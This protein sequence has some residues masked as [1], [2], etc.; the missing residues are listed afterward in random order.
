[1]RMRNA[2]DSE[3]SNLVIYS[4]AINILT[5]R[6]IVARVP[7][8][9]DTREDDPQ[10]IKRK[11]EGPG[12]KRRASLACDTCR[13]QKE[14]CEGGP[15]C[16]RCQ[17][18]SRPCHF[19]EQ[20]V[21]KKATFVVSRQPPPPALTDSDQRV[22]NLEHIVRHFLGDV[23]LD[24]ENTSRIAS[25]CLENNSEVESLLDFNESFDVQFVSRNVAFCPGE[26]SHWNF[27]EKL[28]RTTSS[29]NDTPALGV[30]GYW[31]PSHLQSSIHIVTEVIAQLSPEPTATFLVGVFF[32]YAEGNAF[33]LEKAWTHDKLQLCYQAPTKLSGKDMPWLCSLF[34]V[35]AIGTQMAHMEDDRSDPN[36]GEPE[37][38]A[39]CVEDTVGLAF[40][41]VA[42]KLV[43]DVI[44]AAS[45]ESVQAF[46]LLATWALPVSAGGLSYT[47]LGL[48]MKMA[49]QNGM[50]R[51]Y[52]GGN[53]DSRT[54]E[55]RNRL[56][57]SAYTLENC[58]SNF[59]ASVN[60]H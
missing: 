40:Y 28:R 57:W 36:P 8:S 47:Y 24:E 30:K 12:S 22:Q 45:Y 33:Y 23:S 16:W 27:S 54:I 26:F 38:A 5:D 58:A 18:L 29:N 4:S 2:R 14:K 11:R 56:F 46:V 43:P 6:A 7:M 15:P 19:Q 51:K 25:K 3:L 34:S 49:I 37:E 48:A 44:L 42:S 53:S 17:R 35:L 41:H 31:R 39:E 55:L 60:Q 1:M 10:G 21:P 20:P 52:A 13:R 32:K 50:H 9:L 59:C